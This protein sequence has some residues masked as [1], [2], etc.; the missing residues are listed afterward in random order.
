MAVPSFFTSE[1]SFDRSKST[2]IYRQLVAEIR[3]AIHEK[4]LSPGAQLPATRTLA[5]ALG[6]SRTTVVKAYRKL[7]EEGYFR[8]HIGSG[9]YVA[10]QLTEKHT[11]VQNTSEEAPL[12]LQLT[13]VE[14]RS[15]SFPTRVR[16]ALDQPFSRLEAPNFQKAFRPGIPA[17]D[18]FPIETWSRLVSQHWRTVDSEE[19]V[20]GSPAG[21]ASLRAEVAEYLRTTR[22]VR[23]E[24]DQILIVSGV[25]QALSLTA[26]TLL[27][28][29]DT[30]VVEDP[31]FPHIQR[32]L[33][34]AGASLRHTP[35]DKEGLKHP[36][37]NHQQE[38]RGEESTEHRNPKIVAVTPSHQFPLGVTMSQS[39]RVDLLEWAAQTDT[40]IFEDDYDSQYRYS[41]NPVAALQGMDN[42][43]RVLYAGTF[44]K[45]LF[46]ALRIGYLVVPPDL[47][48]TM[49][50][51]RA[52]FDRCPPRIIQQVLVDF[53]QDGYLEE[54]IG[55][56]R[57]LYTNRQSLLMDAIDKHLPDL[58]TVAPS[59]AGLHLVGWL[60][61]GTDDKAVSKLLRE[62]NILAPPLSFY[63]DC[64]PKRS[65]ILLG[66][67]GVPEE[68]IEENV[69]RM[70]GLLKQA[71]TEL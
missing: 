24:A 22:G 26:S 64:H 50:Q 3:K 6:V 9:T 18:A 11:E 16:Q 57:T 53:I 27:Q 30:A 49:T 10:E 66:Y 60:P 59:N 65:A 47:V 20:Y 29:G 2:P 40:W 13:N 28:R 55:K 33:T 61:E 23:C 71:Q 45:V 8:S 7:R 48:E 51:M 37:N 44:S 15:L 4:I 25:Q 36:F 68:K 67:A 17:L 42:S 38:E 31:G 62:H 39:R 5:E 69:E 63:T 19:L 46:P 54:H 14:A 56:M 32:S 34:A 58:I 12:S 70:A 35:V 52:L 21:L 43:G 41:G 1:L